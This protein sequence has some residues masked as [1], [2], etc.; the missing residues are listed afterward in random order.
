MQSSLLHTKLHRPTAITTSIPPLRLL[1]R[2]QEGLRGKVTLVSAAAGSGKTTLLGAWLDQLT[3]PSAPSL[4]IKASWLTLDKADNQLPRFLGYLVAAIEENFPRSCVAVT[5]LQQQHP[6]PTIEALA[7]ALANSLALLSGQLVLV[8]DDLHLIDNAAIYALLA[9]LIQHAPATFHFVLSTRVDPPLPLN[10]W[11]AHGWLNEVRQQELYFTMEEATTFLAKNLGSPPPTEISATLH[12]YTE[13][14]PVGLR[15]AALA[16]RGHADPA[17]FLADVAANRNRYVIDYLRDDVLDQ[18]PAAVQEFLICTAILKRFCPA[19]CAAVLQIEEAEAQQQLQ[20]VER[21][22]LFLVELGSPSLWYRYHHQFQNMLLAKLHER[23]APTAVVPL[24]QRA[25]AWLAEHGTIQEALYYLTTIADFDAAAALIERHRVA[26]LTEQRF[27]ELAEALTFIPEALCKQRPALLLSRAWVHTHRLDSRQCAATV[28]QLEHLLRTQAVAMPEAMQ[29][30]LQLELVALRCA[31]DHVQESTV[32]LAQIQ[33]AWACAQPYLMHVFSDV[34]IPLADRCQRLGAVE[35]G[36]AIFDTALAQVGARSQM[37]RCLLL[38]AR[39]L[40]HFY[41]CDLHQAE[42]DFQTNLHQA[43]QFDLALIATFSRFMLG[44]IASARH[45]PAVAEAYYTEVLTTPH[46]HWHV[47]RYA[48]LSLIKLIELY[49][50]QGCPQRAQPFLEQLKE[51]AQLVGLGYLHDQVAALDAYFALACGDLPHALRWALDGLDSAL[52]G[53]MVSSADRIPVLRVRILMAEGSPASLHK[54]AQ[55]LQAFLH[56]QERQHR[57]YYLVEGSI[58]LALTWAKLGQMERALAVLGAVVQ[59]AVP[60]GVIGHFIL[61]GSSLKALLHVL[62]QH[63]DYMLLVDLLVA[64]FPAAG[65]APT[66]PVEPVSALLTERELDVLRLLA[67]RL[68]NKEIAERLVISTHTVRNHRANIFSKLQ[69]SSRLQA[70]A[71]A[72]SLGLLSAG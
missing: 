44:V 39:A 18:Q 37:A 16:L 70:V 22:N 66:Q 30:L 52:N 1:H 71:C 68:S 69:A 15:L 10:R 24:Y 31:L 57:K 12:K 21:T 14:W 7:D 3:T 43:Q 55:I 42:R 40:L 4:A 45:Q 47:G 49:T 59:I 28:Q 23:Y 25:A 50:F 54:A 8:L 48:V 72:R 29:C 65:A 5:A 58:L 62:G 63:P 26:L 27:H 32:S 56:Y 20:Y 53:V 64:A 60:N 19:L 17:L 2:L 36:L 13:G 46:F 51:Q 61:Q 33:A 38:N 35:T 11:R 41:E 6:D 67:E 34:V 9:R